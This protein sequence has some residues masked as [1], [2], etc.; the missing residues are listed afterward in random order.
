MP[1]NETKVAVTLTSAATAGKA[2]SGL[3]VR[4]QTAGRLTEQIPQTANFKLSYL[5]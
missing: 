1:G 5:C 2:T 4:D 3:F